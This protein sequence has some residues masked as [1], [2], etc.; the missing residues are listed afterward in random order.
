MSTVVELAKVVPGFADPV[1]DSQRVFR[2]LMNAMARPGRL[3]DLDAGI[4]PPVA[5]YEAVGAMA[6]TLLDFGTPV[7]LPEGETGDL[8][9]NW[10]RFHCGCPVTNEHHQ[11]AFA[12]A[13]ADAVPPLDWFNP[14]DAKYPDRSTTLL[15]LCPSLVG[16]PTLQLTGPGIKNEISIS[17]SGLPIS[18][19]TAVTENRAQFQL[20][21]DIVLA[22]ADTIIGL[23]R[24]TRI[25]EGE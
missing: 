22:C 9:A 7:S 21:V 24:S 20:G 14:G 15:I 23:P 10:L 6:L 3:T 12:I 2:R 16:G 13:C 5:G 25:S 19:W 18:F 8:L 17:P 11:A 1:I 4:V